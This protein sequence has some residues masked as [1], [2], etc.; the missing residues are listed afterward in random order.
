MNRRLLTMKGHFRPYLS[1][2]S[3]KIIEPTDLNMR[4][5]VIPHV[6]SVVV[7]S[8]SSARSETVRLTV[9]K[10]NASQV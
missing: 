8:N 9:K 10:S 2:A 7:L 6:M 3:P 5:N 1:A 4:T